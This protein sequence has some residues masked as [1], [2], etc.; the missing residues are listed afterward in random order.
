MRTSLENSRLKEA[1]YKSQ[2]DGVNSLK[3]SADS[4]NSAATFS[5]VGASL[6][7]ASSIATLGMSAAVYGQSN[8]MKKKTYLMNNLINDNK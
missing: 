5:L 3:A 4:A 7:A 1:E 6:S 2:A 8:K